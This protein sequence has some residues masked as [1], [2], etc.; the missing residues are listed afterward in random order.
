MDIIPQIRL[1]NASVKY[2]PEL[3]MMEVYKMP[4]GMI[5]GVG[6]GKRG[7]SKKSEEMKARYQQQ[8]AIRAGTRIRELIL[9]N[10]LRYLWTLT[11]GE[12]VT[13]RQ[14][15][16]Q[17]FKKFIKRLNYAVGDK[18]QYV[19]VMEIQEKRA[20]RYGKNV[21]HLHMAVDR[22]IN[23]KEV[24]ESA[25]GHGFT[26]VSDHSG[27]ILEVASYMAKYVK[28]GFNDERVRAGE[29]KRYFC[30]Q[31]LIRPERCSMYLTAEEVGRL[32]ALADVVVEYNGARWYQI[33]NVNEKGKKFVDH[34][35]K[36]ETERSWR[37]F[38]VPVKEVG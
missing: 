2:F 3:N 33:R 14:Q 11:Y 12:E 36:E 21:I 28:K 27:K 5:T 29:K 26:F 30:S 13:D 1:V 23:K 32:E 6:G 8:S 25:W 10:N 35:F 16:A 15:V 24:L 17:D 20:K 4:G 34:F 19:A 37:F 38:K 22:W 18:V 7:Q 9:A 31:G